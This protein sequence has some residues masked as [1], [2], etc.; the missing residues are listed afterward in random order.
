MSYIFVKKYFSVYFFLFFAVK[1]MRKEG[2]YFCLRV[3]LFSF[4]V[5]AISCNGRKKEKKITDLQPNVSI[6]KTY[7]DGKRHVNSYNFDNLEKLI[8]LHNDT[9]YVVN[10]WATWCAP[11]VE[12]L[13]YFEKINQTMKNKKV[14]VILVNLDFPNN[15]VNRLLPFMNK[16]N[17]QSKVL[18][19]DDADANN[20][21]PRID[22]NWDGNIP[23]TIIHQKDKRMFYN[24][25]FTEQELYL[26][27]STFINK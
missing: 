17:I 15:I 8:T 7:S 13:P 5:L 24:Q 27:I 21:I 2:F 16:H 19:L 25:A 20:W 4:S 14:R 3:V 22:P 12:E 26:A 23:V 11:C 6:L 9:T 18:I 1:R 10:F